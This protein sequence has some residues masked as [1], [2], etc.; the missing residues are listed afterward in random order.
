MNEIIVDTGPIVALLN[1]RDAYHEWARETLDGLAPPLLT[2]EPVIAEASYIVRRLD[3]GPAAVLDLVTRGVL[4]V[5][6]RVD[7][8]LLALRTLI[9]K[10]ASV[11]MSLADACLVRMAEM[12][13][14][15]AIVTLDS[16]FGI[17][18]RS[19]RHTLRLIRPS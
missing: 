7:S 13:P 3:G 5:A 15:A 2:C 18:R 10:Y 6:F 12:R 4:E 14:R 17:Y 9:T 19:G 1:Q 8:E 16:D 11:P